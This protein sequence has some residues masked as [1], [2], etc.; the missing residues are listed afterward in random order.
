MHVLVQKSP[1]A[2]HILNISLPVELA[3]RGM[4][5]GP[6][7]NLNDSDINKMKD[8]DGG[9][10]T[11]G[12][13]NKIKNDYLIIWEYSGKFAGKDKTDAKKLGQLY[14]KLDI[15][16][17]SYFCFLQAT[18]TRRRNMKSTLFTFLAPQ[19]CVGSSQSIHNGVIELVMYL[20]V[21]VSK[22]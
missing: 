1:F 4:S 17:S 20:T 7:T 2:S 3:T 11:V 9:I 5:M 16:E 19:H 6:A 14:D 13:W 12:I 8:K 15:V 21:L 10:H 18:Q 22:E